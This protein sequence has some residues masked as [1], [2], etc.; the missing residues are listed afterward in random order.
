MVNQP[1]LNKMNCSY[2]VFMLFRWYN[3]SVPRVRLRE[4][5]KPQ[6]KRIAAFNSTSVAY[7]ISKIVPYSCRP[8]LYSKT[9]KQKP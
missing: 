7:N 6:S 4:V 2:F 8:L 9:L 5:L 3:S 1:P